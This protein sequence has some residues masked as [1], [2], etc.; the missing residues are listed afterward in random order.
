MEVILLEKISKLGNIGETVKVR[1][2]Y[3]RNYL[4]PKKA[5]IRATEANKKV[6]EEK[7]DELEK[8]NLK[9][10][11]EAKK[12]LELLPKSIIL[13]REASE[14]GALFGSVTS[15]DIVKEINELKKISLNAKDIILKSNI[16]NLGNYKAEVILHAE[17]T[18]IIEVN[19]KNVEESE[20]Q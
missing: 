14:Q 7:K 19:V 6:F 11:E 13:F 18:S 4:I 16:K 1:D 12:V 9:K 8:A 15:R 10:I 2:G 3:A 20:S 5:A 17:V